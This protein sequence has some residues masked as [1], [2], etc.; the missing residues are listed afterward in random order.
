MGFLCEWEE[1]LTETVEGDGEEVVDGDHPEAAGED[2][3][4]A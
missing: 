2:D 4:E 3:D 1:W